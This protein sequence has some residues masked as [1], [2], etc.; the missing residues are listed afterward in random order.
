MVLKQVT[1]KTL[2]KGKLRHNEAM[3]IGVL[4][5]QGAFREHKLVFEKLGVKVSEVRLR[6]DLADISGLVIPGGES[7]TMAKLMK[8]YEFDTAIPEFYQSGKALWGTCAGAIAISNEII[9]Y[10]E[11]PRLN[12]MNISVERNAY[13]RQVSSFEVDLPIKGFETPFRTVFI[14]APRI[15]KTGTNVEILAEYNGDAIM[16]KQDKLMATVFHPELS[17]DTRVHE[18]FLGMCD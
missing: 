16:A 14:R 18:Y 13:G 7:T 17:N 4:A 9:G 2:K 5:L 6:K 15:A 8:L 3:H 1:I 12:L 10:P 11:Q